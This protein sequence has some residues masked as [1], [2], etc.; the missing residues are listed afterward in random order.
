VFGRVLGR[1]G[2]SITI[3]LYQPKKISEIFASEP[4][5]NGIGSTPMTEADGVAQQNCRNLMGLV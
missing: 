4:K 5:L 3:E 1:R 2:K